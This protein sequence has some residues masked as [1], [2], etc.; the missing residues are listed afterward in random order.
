MRPRCV[1]GAVESS[2]KGDGQ[3][4]PF[5]SFFKRKIILKR[6]NKNTQGKSSIILRLM[7]NDFCS[8]H[9]PTC[10]VDFNAKTFVVKTGESVKLQIVCSCGDSG[11]GGCC[12]GGGV[13]SFF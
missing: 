7:R 13:P 1:P 5:S 4:T 11:G 9:P 2:Q 3:G 8:N 10:L 12:G 6:N